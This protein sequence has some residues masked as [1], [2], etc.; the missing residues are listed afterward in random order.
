MVGGPAR[1]P[2]ARVRRCAYAHRL[3]Q[4]PSAR[5]LVAEA[6]DAIRCGGCRRSPGPLVWPFVSTK[7]FRFLHR[8]RRLL[9]RPLLTP[10]SASSASPF[11]AQ[12]EVS[13]GKNV[14]LPRATVRSTAPAFGHEGFAIV[15]SL[16][17]AGT[18]SYR[19]PVRRPASSLP[20]SSRPSLAL[21][22]LRFASVP[23]ARSREDLHLQVD[24]H[25]G[26]TNEDRRPRPAA[27]RDVSPSKIRE[28]PAP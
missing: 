8:L 5:A 4:Y 9:L 15:W 21:G 19:L 26:R 23:A 20:A 6:S 1:L 27:E 12:G 10:R 7:D 28:S 14:G 16:A 11:Q 18:A 17:L 13:P 24:A 2:P 22:P 3:H 25:A